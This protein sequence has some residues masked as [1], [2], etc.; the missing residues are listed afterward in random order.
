MLLIKYYIALTSR[1]RRNCQ[2]HEGE[3]RQ[4]RKI[5]NRQQKCYKHQE[6][7]FGRLCNPEIFVVFYQDGDRSIIYGKPISDMAAKFELPEW[8]K[9][10]ET[11]D[12]R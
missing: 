11:T 2:G 9:T 5:C 1:K 8:R 4:R 6:P 10:C 7:M 12:D 3:N